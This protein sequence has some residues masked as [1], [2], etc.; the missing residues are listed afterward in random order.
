MAIT[1]GIGRTF[2]TAAVGSIARNAART[3]GATDVG[4]SLRVRIINEKLEEPIPFCR[5][6]QY[7]SGAGGA[8]GPT[9][10]MFETTP[11]IVAKLV[12]VT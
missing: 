6:D 12:S 11:I 2:A 3:A 1:A 5:Y 10:R 4:S 7:I 9:F 8:T